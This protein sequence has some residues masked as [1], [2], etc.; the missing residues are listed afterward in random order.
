[1]SASMSHE[2]SAEPNLVP[3]LDMVFQLITFF[4][5]VLNFK[6]QSMDLNLQLPVLGSAR[7]VKPGVGETRARRSTPASVFSRDDL[8]TF[9]RPMKANSGSDSSGHADKSGALQSNMADGM[10]T[11]K[12]RRPKYR[13]KSPALTQPNFP[14]P[15]K[16]KTG[17]QAPCGNFAS[18]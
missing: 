1:M 16:I 8:P 15:Q 10:F 4:M 14:T 13:N 6:A 12:N 18:R 5:L 2:S 11:I 7:P 9:E 3:I 17:D